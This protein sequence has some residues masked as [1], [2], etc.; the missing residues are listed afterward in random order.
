MT[1]L[2]KAMMIM[3]ATNQ[4]TDLDKHH[5]LIIGSILQGE[6]G[7]GTRLIFEDLWGKYSGGE[8]AAAQNDT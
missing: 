7:Q 2:E 1:N 6:L 3:K 4:G 5:Q 8:N